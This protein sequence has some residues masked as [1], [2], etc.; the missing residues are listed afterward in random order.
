MYAKTLGGV[1]VRQRNLCT[2]EHMDRRIIC[3][4]KS[5]IA[6][7]TGLVASESNHLLR[8]KPEIIQLTRFDPQ[9][10]VPRDLTVHARRSGASIG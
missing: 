1:K 3:G 10:D 6:E 7:R 8:Q 9:L 5:L 2:F 4:Y